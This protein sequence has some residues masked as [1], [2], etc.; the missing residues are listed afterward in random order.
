M[1][2]INLTEQIRQMKN[3]F[4]GVWSVVVLVVLTT[5]GVWAQKGP[6][7]VSVET[8][9]NS[10]CKQWYDISTLNLAD[11]D[12]VD[13]LQDLSLSEYNN[14]AF[15]DTA[16]YRPIYRSSSSAG[17]Y[18]RPAL[19]FVSSVNAKYMLLESSLDVNLQKPMSERTIFI[20]FRTGNDVDTRQI[21]YEQGGI[22]RGLN[23]EIYQG[24]IYV[25]A[26]DRKNDADGTPVFYG[27]S[28]ISEDVLR[29]WNYTIS[30]V[31]DGSPGSLTGTLTAYLNGVPFSSGPAVVGSIWEHPGE[32]AIG[33]V[34]GRAYLHDGFVADVIDSNNG[35]QTFVGLFGEMISY[36]NLLHDAE[37]IIVENYLGSKYLPGTWANSKYAYQNSHRDR[38]FGIGQLNGL[39]H[40][41]SQGA[42]IFEISGDPLNF[43]DNEFLLIGDN[44]GDLNATTINVPNN[45]SNTKRVGREWRV[46][47][48]GDMGPITIRVEVA[49]LPAL[50]S[51]FTKYVL[52]KD[53]KAGITSKFAGSNVDVIELVDEGNGYYSAT[54]D[55]NDGVYL[56][57]GLIKPQVSFTAATA[58]GFE[59]NINT[60]N[61]V[62]AQLNYF[63]AAA[64]SFGYNFVSGSANAISDYLAATGTVTFSA[65]IKT[66]N[67]SFNIVGD[68][69][70]ESSETFTINLVANGSSTTGLSAGVIPSL[71]FSIYDNDNLP[72]VSF[73][74]DMANVN[75]DADSILV[76]VVR[77]GDP[78]V[79]FTV[80][81]R[82][83]TSGTSGTA[84]NGND[85]VFA[86]PQVINFA[87]GEILKQV[88]IYLND[89][90]ID[91]DD[92]TV[93]LELYNVSGLV[94][95]VT[96]LE[97]ELNIL[98]DDVMPVIEF[99][100]STYFAPESF[101]TPDIEVVLSAPS[102]KDIQI[103]YSIDLGSS[104]AT[105]VQD[106]NAP[107][108]GLL[109][110]PAGDSSVRVPIFVV[111]DGQVENDET[112]VIDLLNNA[113]LLNATIG[114][115]DEHTFT[116][117]DYQ[118]FEWFGPAGI[119]NNDE[120]PVWIDANREP[121]NNG[122]VA[123]SLSNFG[124]PSLITNSATNGGAVL[125]STNGTLI[126]GK[127]TFNFNGNDAYRFNSNELINGSA[128]TR[129]LFM[130]I[131][132][133][134]DVNTRQ[135]IYDAGGIINGYNV[136]L[137][138][139]QLYFNMHTE[140]APTPWGV[141]V[142]LADARYLSAPVNANSEYII[143]CRFDHELKY[144]SDKM[145][146]WI[147]GSKVAGRS[148]ADIVQHFRHNFHVIGRLDAG[149]MHDGNSSNSFYSGSISEVINF[150]NA[151]ITPVRQKLVL[152]YL[153]A[154][155]S[156]SMT[157]A[158]HNITFPSDFRGYSAGIGGLGVK[159]DHLDAKG[160]GF[161]RINNARD[162]DSTEYLFWT[163][164]T[165]SITDSITTQLPG[166]IP[167]RIAKV[168]KVAESGEV[169][170]V[171]VSF[172]LS[173]LDL[174]NKTVNDFE[175]L[176]HNNT[177]PNDFTGAT[178]HIIG[179]TMGVSS[180]SFTNVDLNDGDYF[181]LSLQ[182]GSCIEGLWVGDVNNDWNDPNNWDC[183][184]V[185]T[186]TT[187][188]VIPAGVPNFPILNAGVV[189]P[190][191]DITVDAGAIITNV[192]IAG[193][194]PTIEVYG[195][196]SNSGTVNGAL[197][198]SFVGSTEQT[199]DGDNTFAV[200]NINNT[201]GVS[202]SGGDQVITERLELENG[203]FSTGGAVTMR[204]T[205]FATAYINDFSAGY[206][207]SISGYITV[208]RY[209]GSA[210]S[211][212]HYVG[213]PVIG[214]SIGQ[215]N[216]DMSNTTMNG[217]GNGSQVT[218]S[219]SCSF[220]ELAVGSAYGNVFD[221]RENSVTTCE[222]QGWHVRTSGAVNTA[223]GIA[224][225]VNSGVTLDQTG[226]YL[227]GN[228]NSVPLTYTG[229]N[230]SGKI[231][232]NL[233]ANPYQSDINWGDVA[234]SG[235][236]NNITGEAFVFVTSGAY[237]GTF[238]TYNL[239]NNANL[240]PGQA[241]F[242]ITTANNST[243]DF[244]NS[245][246]RASA[247]T[248]YRGGTSF[249]RKLDLSIQ[250]NGSADI[251]TLFFDQDFTTG[252]D[253]LYDGRKM[254]SAN[255]K[256]T[257]YTYTDN[258]IG[259]QSLNA[260]PNDGS[261][262]TVPV[263][264]AVGTNGTYTI[265]AN[266]VNGFGN[267]ALVLLEDLKTGTMH[268]LRGGSY[269]FTANVQDDEMRFV[270]HFV[271]EANIT[272]T[273][274]GCDGTGSNITV[275]MGTHT[276]NTATILWDEITVTDVNGNNQMIN[277]VSGVAYQANDVDAGNYT[278][279]FT[280]GTYTTTE[281]VEI[282]AAD[283]VIVDAELSANELNIGEPIYLTDLTTGATNI[284][285]E[286]GDGST[287]SNVNSFAH[288]YLTEGVYN[289]KLS[290]SNTEC[291][292][293]KN[294]RVTVTNKT[295]GIANAEGLDAISMY[296]DQQNI[297][298]N[299]NSY[300]KDEEAKVELYNMVG[301]LMVP[302]TKVRT[303]GMVNLNMNDALAPGMYIVVLDMGK[304][305]TID[306]KVMVSG[307]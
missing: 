131:R 187:D 282:I 254:K 304:G 44:G 92:E 255:G 155:Y 223:Q 41:T 72:E 75:E 128:D 251:T 60:I 35:A 3:F 246:R 145:E 189:Y 115:V 26:Y 173:R 306:R 239:A 43:Q 256:S 234:S 34:N 191:A 57:F 64:T 193:V 148:D 286:L 152:S 7:G 183:G 284:V 55:L 129:D 298:L 247:G 89:D 96:P 197:Q 98:D 241:F 19:S 24:K 106:Y 221:Y 232:R 88:V 262:T 211:G 190:A 66:Q 90:D 16:A 30:I 300:T 73:A 160:P 279:T 111:Q 171:S 67:I 109:V 265:E 22:D 213:F 31:F 162:A 217:A 218:P 181:S 113:N 269:S 63:P 274:V 116:I 14:V 198:A 249:E 56:T 133:G 124:L 242:V 303:V 174:S 149:L 80:N 299:F 38:V 228:I 108:T 156:I 158:M 62:T 169:G 186:S 53:N 270:L 114:N 110:I 17:L 206:T 143:Y 278:V 243:L 201:S 172:D 10:T 125:N 179:R 260:L 291:T 77:A 151:P 119:A 23:I 45:S 83:R 177:D 139:G 48:T 6:G 207:G 29:D 271:P 164:N 219:A 33:A 112:V 253:R 154:K 166:G 135:V 99:N 208:E 236:N 289:I 95:L 252:F 144:G 15:Q 272:A 117:K 81:C 159:G 118:V 21:V 42:G 69:T 192:S 176:I 136:Y 138:N 8:I 27:P 266:L 141:V 293:E 120:V 210:A 65:G 132:T 2:L 126:N 104:T 280:Y 52:I 244:D 1:Q 87:S 307:K 222:L 276:V 216:D 199:I 235:S 248:F 32:P 209:I 127:P 142:S 227:T 195:N 250:G 134:N 105:S 292:D 224:I 50:G 137:L 185:P 9:N 101:N 263:G 103:E 212:F 68:L 122:Q 275:D 301:Q 237:Q 40:N 167:S 264:F 168:Y 194:K 71:E 61:S 202:I 97:Y 257:L 46:D 163:P 76:D 153:S 58:Y 258:A 28:S 74:T 146:L 273:A 121:L 188:V 178:R 180:V 54:T 93:Y 123:N 25:N 79:A 196:W 267:T 140:Y 283:R 47:H 203:T 277:N 295:T 107:T 238:T 82:L 51:G 150:Q 102:S 13:T 294:F 4:A 297:Y 100:T 259:M 184:V 200:L 70:G 231:G 268:N 302:S 281:V 12:P 20:N 157:D 147:N 225:N 245:M 91:E 182:P 204:S 11:G 214:A 161:V 215:L 233:V 175:L 18:G 287:V 49:L 285:W 78:S 165:A 5:S 288:S 37:R 84:T 290:A 205:A 229:S 230:T 240:S 59:D 39:Y 85:Y 305:H 261:V 296:A 130:V 36:N 220:T 170:T 86:S 94:D 226:G